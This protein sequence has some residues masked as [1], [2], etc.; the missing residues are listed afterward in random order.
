MTDRPETPP[1]RQPRRPL[2]AGEADSEQY[3]RFLEAAREL[4]CEEHADRLNEVLRR[5][6]KMPPPRQGSTTL[7]KRKESGS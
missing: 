5:V 1:K 3:A 6:A 2:K 4:G 7:R